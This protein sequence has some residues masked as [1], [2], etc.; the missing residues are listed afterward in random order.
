MLP[1]HDEE[2]LDTLAS[3]TSKLLELP[4]TNWLTLNKQKLPEVEEEEVEI[5]LAYRYVCSQSTVRA[6]PIGNL[7]WQRIECQ[8]DTVNSVQCILVSTVQ[9]AVHG[10]ALDGHRACQI[11][12]NHC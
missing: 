8:L 10:Q 3:E 1:V 6:W 9:S 5:K 11:I 2:V 12:Y 7:G 4:E